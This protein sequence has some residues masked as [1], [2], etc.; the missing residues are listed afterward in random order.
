[1]GVTVF[2]DKYVRVT[3][4]WN[5]QETQIYV[6]IKKSLQ[7]ALKEAKQIDRKLLEQQNE[8]LAG[9]EQSGDRYF[10]EDG[11]IVGLRIVTP[12]EGKNGKPPTS[13]GE[14]KPGDPLFLAIAASHQGLEKLFRE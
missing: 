2:N 5:K 9:Q 10:H 3:R 7:A 11:S 4:A 6:P 13:A 14:P 1:M 12:G 8:F